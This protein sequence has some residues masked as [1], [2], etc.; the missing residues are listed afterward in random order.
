MKKC[1]IVYPHFAHYREH[2][3]HELHLQSDWDFELVSGD[4]KDSQI[5]CISPELSKVPRAGGGFRWTFLKNIWLLGAKKPFL[6]QQG[7][8][9]RLT[10]SDY[11]TVV[12]LGSIYYISTWVALVFLKL[13]R[14]K[15]VFW[16]HG[17]L[18]KDRFVIS[19]IR[20]LMYRRADACMLYGD[21]ARRIMMDAGGYREGSLRVIYNSI[22][23]DDLLNA[24]RYVDD[25]E[26]LSLRKSLFKEAD[27]PV[28]VAVG[29]L[30]L[31]KRI[32]LLID[33]LVLSIKSGVMFNI[34]IVGDGPELLNLKKQVDKLNIEAYV[35][36]YGAA[37]GDTA[38]SLMLCADLSVIPGNVGLSAMHAM[39]AGLPVISHDNFDIQMPEHEAILDGVTGSF[40]KYGSIESLSQQIV[41]WISDPDLLNRSHSECRKVIKE[42]YHKKVQVR[43]IISMLEGM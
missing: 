35:N 21:R 31:V 23:C 37:Y 3:L 10:Q 42:R 8:L 5:K 39:A 29:R 28:V 13:N 26:L 16:T 33:S 34:L 17:F 38:D 15:I 19:A 20:H 40:Y 14:K 11:D 7:L 22:E 9:G 2:I 12:F 1:L 43:E 25:G 27:L 30:N 41:R 24:K 6:W 36:F 32:N 18:G 4:G